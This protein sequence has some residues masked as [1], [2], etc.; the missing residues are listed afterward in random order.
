MI[1]TNGRHGES[2]ACTAPVAGNSAM[3]ASVAAIR[4]ASGFMASLL[5]GYPALAGAGRAGGD[6]VA[7]RLP[8]NTVM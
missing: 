7:S 1:E 3:S 8:P 5:P 6:A 2:C 4:M